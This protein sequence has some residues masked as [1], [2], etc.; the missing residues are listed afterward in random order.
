[1]E[2]KNRKR[3]VIIMV[4]LIIIALIS[5]FFY[6]ILKPKET[7]SDKIKNQNE[8][9]VDCGGICPKCQVIK[10]D[11]LKIGNKRYIDSGIEGKYDFWAEVSNPNN[12]FGSQNFKYKITLKDT[13]GNIAGERNGQSFI[14]PGEKKYI[15]ENNIPA[16]NPARVEFSVSDVKWNEFNNDYEK[17]TLDIVNKNYDEINSGTGFSEAKG[18]LKNESPFDFSIIKVKVLL[19]D[20]AGNIIALNSTEMNAV[21][22]REER[23]FRVFWPTRF[24]GKVSNIEAQAEVNVFDSQTFLKRYFKEQQFQQ[25]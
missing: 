15:I 17:P 1:M 3:I 11:D 5:L 24:P 12:I 2:N 13:D 23:E 25:Y 22:S 20:E 4:Y 19:K 14:L 6:M 21:K 7:C 18:L 16:K 9:E 8:E 10:A